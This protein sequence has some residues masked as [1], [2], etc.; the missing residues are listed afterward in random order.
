MNEPGG[1]VPGPGCPGPARRLTGVG[2]AWIGL[3][4]G[5][6]PNAPAGDGYW[7]GGARRSRRGGYSP[8][9]EVLAGG[10]RERA[11]RGPGL[12]RRGGLAGVRLAG[13]R[14]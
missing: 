5:G 9:C 4:G 2:L 10:S 11:G 13:L 8:G 7:P 6:P 3:A 1:G 12:R 14:A